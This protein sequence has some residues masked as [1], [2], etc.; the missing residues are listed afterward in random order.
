MPWMV[1]LFGVM[2]IPAGVT[3]IAL[4]ILQ[5][6]GVGAWCF[7]CL[8]TAFIMLL[9][10]A[11]ALDEVVATVQF[12]RQSHKQGK[13]FWRT[14]LRGEPITA[15]E[16]LETPTPETGK[17]LPGKLKPTLPL[18]LVGSIIVGG[19][20]MFSPAF[21]EIVKPASNL[22]YF[23]SALILTF[24]I[25][26]LSEIARVARFLNIIIGA[27]LVLCIWLLD[28]SSLEA[29]WI[30][31]LCSIAIITLSLPKGKFRKHFGSYDKLARWSPLEG[32][33]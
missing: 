27:A 25:I 20:L 10:V 2:I 28:G 5:P 19:W 11:P 26:A 15:E 14:F 23:S 22:V 1:I 16:I 24:G 31:T 18:G 12:L 21:L 33:R 30:V 17:H 3:S 9:M 29:R 4:V 8:L 32:S 6:V 13:P 7:L